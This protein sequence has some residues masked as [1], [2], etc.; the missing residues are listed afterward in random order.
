VSV[1]FPEDQ[2]LAVPGISAASH[3]VIMSAQ[4]VGKA[5]I[6]PRSGSPDLQS[7]LAGTKPSP[8]AGI[9]GEHLI[10]NRKKIFN[11]GNKRPRGPISFFARRI[12][13]RKPGNDRI[14]SEERSTA[15]NHAQSDCR[16]GRG[17]A[18]ALAMPMGMASRHRDLHR[19]IAADGAT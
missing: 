7:S 15:Q 14:R 16:R 13:F 18:A 6:A 19:L 10:Q 4:A 5:T 1:V 2:V 11:R 3:R 12:S 17:A 9:A 8:Q